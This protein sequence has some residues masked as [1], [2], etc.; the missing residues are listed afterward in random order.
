[1]SQGDVCF[2]P[3]GWW[4]EVA[5][6]AIAAMIIIAAIIIIAAMIVFDA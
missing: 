2:I 4:H 5:H 1:V 3:E 6:T